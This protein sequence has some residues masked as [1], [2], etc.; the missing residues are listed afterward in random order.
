VLALLQAKAAD[1]AEHADVLTVVRCS[2]GLRT[3][4]DHR[5]PTGRA[6]RNDLCDRRGTTEQVRNDDGLRARR[7]D[8]RD[9]L[10]R[11]VCGRRVHVRKHRDRALV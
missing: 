9:R 4:F 1:V 5:D 10:G 3:I 8:V 2:E 7:Q 11:D 6:Q